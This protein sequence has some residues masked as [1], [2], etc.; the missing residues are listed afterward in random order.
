MTPPLSTSRVTFVALTSRPPNLPK[1]P[2]RR[3]LEPQGKEA[4]PL[5]TQAALLTG[6]QLNLIA[7]PFVAF[8]KAFLEMGET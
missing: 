7:E 1:F 2:F 5:A 3:R 6:V 8:S 4:R